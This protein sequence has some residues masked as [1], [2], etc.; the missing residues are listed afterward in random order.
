MSSL[1]SLI[2]SFKIKS[3]ILH[4]VVHKMMTFEKMMTEVELS[5]VIMPS[6]S[7]K[8]VSKPSHSNNLICNYI[9]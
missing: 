6:A 2:A 9:L 8:T 3:L 4:Y 1:T 7:M 5:L